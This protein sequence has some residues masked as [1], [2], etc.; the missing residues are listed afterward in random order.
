[1]SRSSEVPN[2]EFIPEDLL[3]Q[4]EKESW[5]FDYS[6]NKKER[7]ERISSL[8]SLV[9]TYANWQTTGESCFNEGGDSSV[10]IEAV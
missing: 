1:M 4:R 5:M 2:R 8:F 9:P 10:V 3:Q 7:S 6:S